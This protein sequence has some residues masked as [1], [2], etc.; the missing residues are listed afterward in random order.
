MVVASAATPSATPTRTLVRVEIVSI[1]S[2]VTSR[3]LSL[4]CVIIFSPEGVI[5]THELIQ[6]LPNLL[7]Q[8]I[9]LAMR[10]LP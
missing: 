1:T 4:V 10:L 5:L 3:V 2:R 8:L 9:I 7:N 6:A